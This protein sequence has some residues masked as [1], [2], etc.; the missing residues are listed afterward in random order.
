MDLRGMGHGHTRSEKVLPLHA[1]GKNCPSGHTG[2]ITIKLARRTPRFTGKDQS[3][4]SQ[5][6]VDLFVAFIPQ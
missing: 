5:P 1:W 3:P 4:V 6:P 2:T